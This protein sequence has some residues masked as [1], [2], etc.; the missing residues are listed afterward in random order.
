MNS[1]RKKLV[2]VALPLN[3]VDPREVISA[4]LPVYGPSGV[5]T[6]PEGGGREAMFAS[7][8][9]SDSYRANATTA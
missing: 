5:G 2:E 4:K 8:G 7:G 3:G 9:R 6:S 1:Y